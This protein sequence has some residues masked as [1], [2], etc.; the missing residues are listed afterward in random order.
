MSKFKIVVSVSDDYPRRIADHAKIVSLLKAMFNDDNIISQ[1][2][3]LNQI[4]SPTLFIKC[5]KNNLLQLIELI[6]LHIQKIIPNC[7]Q[8]SITHEEVNDEVE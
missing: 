2:I 1:D 3:D 8:Y 5:S 4:G 7:V 6:K